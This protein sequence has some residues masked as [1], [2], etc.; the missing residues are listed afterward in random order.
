MIKYML[1]LTRTDSA[2]SLIFVMYGEQELQDVISCRPRPTVAARHCGHRHVVKLV[3]AIET[4][5][6]KACRHGAS[7]IITVHSVLC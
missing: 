5:G 7:L 4:A 2:L 3:G 1:C 6:L